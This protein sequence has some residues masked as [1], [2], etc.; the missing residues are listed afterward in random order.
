MEDFRSIFLKYCQNLQVC[1]AY[2][3]KMALVIAAFYDVDFADQF[4]ALSLQKEQLQLQV[5]LA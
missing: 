5:I 3:V 4:R 1:A 2:Y